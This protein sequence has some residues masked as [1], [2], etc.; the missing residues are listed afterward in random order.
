MAMKIIKF[1]L[2]E[3]LSVEGDITSRSTIP[4]G[5]QA[6]AVLIAKQMPAVIAGLAIAELVFKTVDPA[7]KFTALIKDGA[8]IEHTPVNIATI[9]G[10]AISVLTAERTALNLIQRMS[11][12]ATHTAV[13]ADK[14]RAVGVAVLD[15]R[16]TVPGL[17]VLDKFA[18]RLGGGTNHRFGLYDQVLIKDNHIACA[19]GIT[20]AVENARK[21]YSDK[22]IEVET[23]NLQE[24]EEALTAKADII[25]LDNMTPQQV[26][27]CVDVIQKRAFVEVSGGITLETFEKYLLPGVDAISI[28]ALTHS[29]KAVDISLEVEIEQ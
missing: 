2:E 28:G 10:P 12:I 15:T 24:V 6:K 20:Q 21:L 18:V 27:Q 26:S 13:Y 23:T 1:A 22:K 7:I 14:A 25:M 4:A 5:K 19:G 29:V 3:D 17:R 9:S 11:G 8:A 16:K